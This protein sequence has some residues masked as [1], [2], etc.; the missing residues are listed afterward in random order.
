VLSAQASRIGPPARPI[1]VYSQGMTRRMCVG[2]ALL[3]AAL[4]IVT[5]LA[6][7][8][9]GSACGSSDGNTLVV[10]SGRTS[11]LVQPLLEQFN[12]ATGIRVEV[13]YS[14]SPGVLSQVLA[15]GNSSPADVV[16]M[17]DPGTLGPLAKAGHLATLPES[18]LSM[19]DDRFRAATGGWV[20]TSG[21]ARTVAYNVALIDPEHDLPDSVLGFTDR[22]WWGRI[23]WAPSGGSFQAFV[24][25]F[26]LRRRRRRRP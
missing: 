15:E 26:Q 11:V 7:L 22:Q 10:Y 24:T 13:R 4:A 14:S 1:R 16:Y 19:V 23:G 9:L 3:R 25:A 5:S 12:E 21:R 20:G 18:L 8:V 6:V 17:T 2:A